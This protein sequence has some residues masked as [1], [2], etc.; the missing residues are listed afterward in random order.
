MDEMHLKSV[1]EGKHEE[2][3]NC[4][5]LYCSCSVACGGRQAGLSAFQ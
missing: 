4:V 2:D 5:A 3:D 1:M